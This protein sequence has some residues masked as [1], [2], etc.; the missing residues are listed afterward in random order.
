MNCNVVT[1]SGTDGGGKMKETG[2]TH[3][4]SPNLGAT[5]SSGFTA[6]PAGYRVSNGS[7]TAIKSLLRKAARTSWSTVSIVEYTSPTSARKPFLVLTRNIFL[8]YPAASCSYF[9]LLLLH[10]LSPPPLTTP[11]LSSPRAVATFS[12]SLLS[13]P[14]LSF[15]PQ[16][17]LTSPPCFIYSR[18]R[19][20][21]AC[22]KREFQ[23]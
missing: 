23:T 12:A 1:W 5:N 20:V 19:C 18:R 9:L 14:L 13:P 2:I 7:F 6:L 22:R 16:L 3:W 17:L 15:P 21:T 11:L 10:I 8:I 4:N